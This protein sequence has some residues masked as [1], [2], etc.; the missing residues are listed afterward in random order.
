M[1]W[2]ANIYFLYGKT[3]VYCAR[4]QQWVHN[5]KEKNN[6]KTEALTTTLI[7]VGIAAAVLLLAGLRI[8][9]TKIDTLFAW[10]SA[11]ALIAMAPVSYRGTWKRIFGS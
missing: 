5:T 8:D 6:M 7:V 9:L 10:A 1:L 4:T 11:G 2:I 3:G